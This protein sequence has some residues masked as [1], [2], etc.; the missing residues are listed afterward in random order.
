MSDGISRRTAMIIA[1]HDVGVYCFRDQDDEKGLWGAGIVL[2]GG[3]TL[4]TC[5]PHYK[6][7]DDAE[8]AMKEVVVG[9]EALGKEEGWF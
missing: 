4:L 7:S 8:A 6:S 2:Q 9:C 1:T 5:E 3:R